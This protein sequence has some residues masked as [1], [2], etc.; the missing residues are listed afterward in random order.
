VK[1]VDEKRR[2]MK[3]LISFLIILT[4]AIGS[5]GTLYSAEQVATCRDV[6]R[7]CT[8]ALDMTQDNYMKEVIGKDKPLPSKAQQNMARHCLNYIVGFKDA[9]YVSQIVQEKNGRVPFVC[10]TE[11]NLNNEQALRIVIKYIQDNPQLLDRPQSAVVF[12]AFYYAYPCKK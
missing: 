7:D 5:S 1:Y 6:L 10:L 11:N 12:N 9:L 4:F 2:L 3:T 8:L